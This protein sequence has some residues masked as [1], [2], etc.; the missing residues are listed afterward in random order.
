MDQYQRL[1]AF[2]E[3]VS[4]AKIHYELNAVRRAVMVQLAVPGQRW[5]IEFMPDGSVEIEKFV[6]DGTLHND[7]ELAELLRD[8]AG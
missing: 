8:F 3:Q 6:S 2:L 5:E 7:S 4:E 1:L